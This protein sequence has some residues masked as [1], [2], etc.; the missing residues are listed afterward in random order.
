MSL[1][2]QQEAFCLEYAAGASGAEAARRSGYSEKSAKQRAAEL[3]RR[4]V[5]AAR[6]AELQAETA[7]DL[8]VTH[9]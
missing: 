6:I 8:G 7:A 5:I 3:V 2:N 1:T 4:P 9:R